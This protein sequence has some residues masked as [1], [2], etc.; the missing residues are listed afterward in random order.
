MTPYEQPTRFVSRYEYANIA[1]RRIVLNAVNLGLKGIG[2]LCAA[3]TLVFLLLL[4]IGCPF[5]ILWWGFWAIGLVASAATYL[6][7]MLC[8]A[9]Y[10]KLQALKAVDLIPY[11]DIAEI[12]VFYSLVRAS[13]EPVRDQADV[14]LRAVVDAQQTLPE[15]L[16]RSSIEAK[17]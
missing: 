12:P 3:I 11:T 16:L 1:V 4:F 10:R 7:S 8:S 13:E 2:G 14:L 9:N 5:Y 15:Q 17:N 6:I